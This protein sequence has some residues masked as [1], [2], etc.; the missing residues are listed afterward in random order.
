M[1]Q[2]GVRIDKDGSD[3]VV[4]GVA[5][6]GLITPDDPLDCGNSGTTMR[7]LSGIVA[8]AGIEATLIGDESLSG[9][10]MK[11]IIDPL[12]SMGAQIEASDNELHRLILS[13]ITASS[14]CGI[15]CQLPALS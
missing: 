15:R 1:R 7:L 8:G 2:L 11:R 3:L 12:R 13:P 14:R 4:H 5:R 6:N 9:R 10:T